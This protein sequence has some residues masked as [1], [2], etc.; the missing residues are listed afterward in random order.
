[1]SRVGVTGRPFVR[2]SCYTCVR[3]PRRRRRRRRRR[4]WAG[5]GAIDCATAGSRKYC[6]QPRPI[7]RLTE[8]PHA[9]FAAA[10][11]TFLYVGCQVVMTGGSM[12][13]QLGRQP[14][15]LIARPDSGGSLVSL[16]PS[17]RLYTAPL[18]LLAPCV[19]SLSVPDD[20]AAVRW[21]S[22]F[23]LALTPVPRWPPIQSITHSLPSLLPPLPSSSAAS[24]SSSSSSST[25]SSFIDC[26]CRDVSQAPP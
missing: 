17:V 5:C 1:M 3:A 10:S 9:L 15:S 7:D 2:R 8:Q 22:C 12:V 4:R 11:L 18:R 24:S 20:G 6:I 23:F 16:P 21:W 19:Q 14:A 13:G 26:C 25:A